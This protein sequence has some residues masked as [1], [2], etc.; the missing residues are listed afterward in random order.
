MGQPPKF[1]T[2]N[3]DHKMNKKESYPTVTSNM[4]EPTEDETAISPNP[5]RATITLVN[6]SGID[7]PAAKKVKPM[8]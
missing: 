3:E 8:T 4:F 1:K 7:V 5:F 2:E 6:K